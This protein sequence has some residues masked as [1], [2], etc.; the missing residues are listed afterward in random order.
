MDFPYIFMLSSTFLSDVWPYGHEK[1]SKLLLS[2]Y[3]YVVD[4][5]TRTSCDVTQTFGNVRRV[6][7]QLRRFFNQKEL[8]T[9]KSLEIGKKNAA[10]LFS[11]R[12]HIKNI[13]K[14]CV[15]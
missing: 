9:N 15:P 10:K 14:S 13:L 1:T 7:G 8:I 12:F 11:V 2:A 5:W 6:L 4:A 3:R